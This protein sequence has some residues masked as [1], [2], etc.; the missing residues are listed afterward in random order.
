MLY[1]TSSAVQSSEA[2]AFLDPSQTLPRLALIGRPLADVAVYGVQKRSTER[3]KR[4]WIARWFG[5]DHGR[6]CPPRTA[7]ATLVI[8]A[9]GEATTAYP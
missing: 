5:S 6:D 3:N 9:D 1:P 8:N 7:I 4:P 2:R